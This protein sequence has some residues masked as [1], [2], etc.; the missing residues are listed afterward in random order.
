VLRGFL[1]AG[2]VTVADRG[3]QGFLTRLLACGEVT[4]AI[5]AQKRSLALGPGFKQKSS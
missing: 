1:F 3:F 2:K 5:L 4:C